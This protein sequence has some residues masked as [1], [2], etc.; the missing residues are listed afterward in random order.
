[1]TRRFRPLSRALLAA[2]LALPLLSGGES[3]ARKKKV[4]APHANVVDDAKA[5][6][7]ST[8]IPP[9]A[10]GEVERFLALW[11]AFE[12]AMKTLSIVEPRPGV[13]PDGL[14]Q[15]EVAFRTDERMRE[16]L[17][18]LGA[19]PDEF[20][21]LYR[22]VSGAWWAMTQQEDH[23]RADAA[24][25]AEVA[26][27][28]RVSGR[29]PKRTGGKRAADEMRKHRQDLEH[30]EDTLPGEIPGPS[31]ETVRRHRDALARIFG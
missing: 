8:P 18:S 22:R 25:D 28:D 30:A 6:P 15:A 1:M 24:L 9:L 14:A 23:A 19:T 11:P 2:A 13:D 29:D 20:L 3:L 5:K 4:R 7:A 31:I 16:S 17:Q 26:E 12:G 27:L 10:D 21:L